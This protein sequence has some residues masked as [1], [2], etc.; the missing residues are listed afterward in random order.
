MPFFRLCNS[1]EDCLLSAR[2]LTWCLFPSLGL[3]KCSHVDSLICH[4]LTPASLQPLLQH[5]CVA[6]IWQGD[7]PAREVL[8]A[9]PQHLH[10]V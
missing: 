8:S 9:L 7:R 4:V 3:G 1:K 2:M 5:N 6:G 10:A